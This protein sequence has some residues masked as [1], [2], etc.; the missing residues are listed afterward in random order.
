LIRPG[1]SRLREEI[2]AAAARPVG[3]VTGESESLPDCNVLIGTEAVLHRAGHADVVAFLDLDA[4]LLAPRYRAA[5]QAM[6]LLARAARLVG[7]RGGGGRLLVQTF[8]PRHEVLQAVLHADPSRV[9]KVELSRRELLGLP[10]F[11]ALAAISGTGAADYAAATG[12]EASST[13]DRV[14]LRAATWDELGAALARTPRP[15]GSRLRVE[16]DP[17]R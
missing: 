17:P 13:G 2:E 16:V 7:G 1:V 6:A 15:K 12:L 4:E 3:M 5:E 9:S 10:P 8:L 11:A 14:L